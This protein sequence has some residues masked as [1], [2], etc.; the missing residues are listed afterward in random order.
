VDDDCTPEMLA[1]L[2]RQREYFAS[3]QLLIDRAKPWRD[4]TPEECLVATM[5]SC[6]EVD[7]MFSMM[8]PEVR[9]RALRPEPIPEG[10]LA[11]LEAMQK[12]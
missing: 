4:A 12:R 7:W 5:E 10:V 2:D 8:E 9:E 1:M 6:R 3:D 11:I